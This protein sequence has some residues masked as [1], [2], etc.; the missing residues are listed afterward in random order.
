MASLNRHIVLTLRIPYSL[1]EVKLSKLSYPRD[2]ISRMKSFKT[3]KN[4]F[5]DISNI[6]RYSFTGSRVLVGGWGFSV[7]LNAFFSKQ[8]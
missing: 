5:F 1:K 6:S 7:T 2:K 8:L 3:K 4:V